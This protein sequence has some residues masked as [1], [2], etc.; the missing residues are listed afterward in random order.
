M[1]PYICPEHPKGQVKHTWDEDLYAYGKKLKK[2]K[3]HN[4][5]YRCVDCGRKLAA[6]LEES[7][8]AAQKRRPDGDNDDKNQQA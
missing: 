1:L 7:S 4:H 8:D 6:T 2:P 5:E 3:I